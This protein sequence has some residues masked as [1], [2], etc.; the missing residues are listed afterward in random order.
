[1][2]PHRFKGDFSRLE[3]E[4]RKK[5][6]P[7]EYIL[8]EMNIQKGDTFI[9]F[10]CGIGYFS[11]PA[12]EFVG[13]EGTVIAIDVSSEMLSELTKRAGN[14]KNLK[15][16]HADTL[17]EVMADIILLSMVLHEI[18]NPKEFL[19]SCVASLKPHGRIM[20]L[21][22]QKHQIAGMGPPVE[23]RLAKEEVLQLAQMR[24]HEHP[25]H[26]LVY[27]LELLPG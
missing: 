2:M 21:D 20:I 1:M 11:I 23:D 14:R 8:K 13:E 19:R 16:V 4:E 25:L 7:V 12:L 26:E 22:W 5:L 9:D 18:E 27:F 17:R 10:G 24:Y 15:I 6:L 3:S